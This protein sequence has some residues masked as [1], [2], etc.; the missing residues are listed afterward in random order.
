MDGAR[1]AAAHVVHDVVAAVQVAGAIGD[2][3]EIPAAERIVGARGIEDAAGATT[4]NIGASQKEGKVYVTF[5]G[6][7]MMDAEGGGPFSPVG[8]V[9]GEGSGQGGEPDGE[10]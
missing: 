7:A 1:H 6:V 4:I 3:H 5:G 2:V 10:R 9:A 8:K